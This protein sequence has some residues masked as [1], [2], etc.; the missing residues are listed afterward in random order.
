VPIK[1][2]S[3]FAH[4]LVPR[5]LRMASLAGFVL[6]R[7]ARILE[8]GCGDGSMVYAWRD[9]GFDAHG[10]DIHDTVRLRSPEDK[11]FFSFGQAVNP[12]KAA[13]TRIDEASFRI[14]FAD[15]TFDFVFSLTVLEH[16]KNHDLALRELSRVMAPKSVGFHV[17]PGSYTLVEPHIGVPLATQIQ[18]RAWF[19]LW[20]ALG[21]RNS[22]QTGMSSEEIAEA[23][24]RYAKTG[25]SYIAPAEMVAIAGRYFNDV[26]FTPQ[27]WEF[28]ARR[29]SALFR[30]ELARRLYTR[31]ENAV[32][33]TGKYSI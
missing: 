7:S 23:N 4:Y 20:A 14:P 16:V 15:G 30:S 10:F 1:H 2:E 22:F 17:F 6:D 29:S 8:F 12:E 9:E 32:L 21:V 18:N 26:R 3:D 5:F 33:M 13:D 25:L 19:R 27:F 28:P 31:F 24:L 11:R